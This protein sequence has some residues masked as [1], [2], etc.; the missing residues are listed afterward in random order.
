VIDAIGKMNMEHTGK[1]Y[2]VI[3]TA[4]FLLV[5]NVAEDLLKLS[6]HQ[7]KTAVAVLT[8]HAAVRKHCILWACLMG[9][10]RADFA[11]WRLKQ[12]SILFAAA[13]CWLVSAIMSLGNC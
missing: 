3:D 2:Q 4:N 1:I 5:D 6:R 9:I 11:G 7:L 10:Q 12:C 13:R 8:G